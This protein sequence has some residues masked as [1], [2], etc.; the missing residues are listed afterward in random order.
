MVSLSSLL[1]IAALVVA[2]VGLYSP[3]QVTMNSVAIVLICFAL[4]VNV[5]R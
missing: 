2:L 5:F 3:R 4:L 1:V